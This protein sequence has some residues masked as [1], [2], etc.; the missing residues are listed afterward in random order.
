MQ[1]KGQKP[2]RN[3]LKVRSTLLALQILLPF[4]L[5]TAMQWEAAPLVWAA[6]GVFILSMGVLV[7]LG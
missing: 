3:N 5:Y 7:W 4:G 2:V 6:A 1:E